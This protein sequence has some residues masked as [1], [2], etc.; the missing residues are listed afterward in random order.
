MRHCWRTGT[1]RA[2]LAAAIAVS[3]ALACQPVCAR[4]GT[5]SPPIGIEE[6]LGRRVPMDLT[7]CDEN[8]ATVKLGSLIKKPTVLSLVYYSCPGICTPLLNGKLEVLDRIGLA[9]GKDF[10]AITVSFD[11]RDTP[12]LAR[13]K[14]DNYTELFSRPF[15]KEAWRFLTGDAQNIARLTEAVGFRYKRE[16]QDF[17]HSGAIFVLSPDGKIARYLY[18]TSFQPFDLQLAITEASKGHTGPTI[19]KMLL[20][21]FSYDPQGRRYFLDITRIA[22]VLVILAAVTAVTTLA[23]IARRRGPRDEAEGQ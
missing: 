20:Y 10:L 7:F 14:R 23:A 12:K 15:P 2:Y 16:G 21:C 11:D 6:H 4:G 19:S 13:Q 3:G 5:S 22:G 1:A 9:P 17:V 8:G 18:G